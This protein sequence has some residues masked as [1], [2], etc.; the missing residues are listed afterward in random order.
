MPSVRRIGT[1]ALR[2]R[3]RTA[4]ACMTVNR[5]WPATA[6]S[7]RLSSSSAS[8]A[9]SGRLILIA[10]MAAWSRACASFPGTF[11]G[12]SPFGRS[13]SASAT[14]CQVS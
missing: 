2:S 5:A 12:A 8:S 13:D 6:G 1:A 14:F 7:I 9:R 11:S 3:M 4:W 10:D